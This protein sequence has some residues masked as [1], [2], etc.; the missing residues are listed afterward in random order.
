M[1]EETKP[2]RIR[3]HV[4][5]ILNTRQL[6]LNIGSSNHVQVGMQFDVVHARNHE[7]KDP[8]SGEFLG[9]LELPKKRV[10]IS[11]V[12]EKYS[13]AST[14]AREVNVGGRGVGWDFANIYAPPKWVTRYDTL[15]K[16]RSSFEEIDESESV[17]KVGDPVVEV[18]TSDAAES[19][20]FIGETASGEAHVS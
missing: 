15:K 3:G 17:V 13:I 1:S 10:K 6:A 20:E 16:S 4:A 12:A 18:V 7:L 5:A 9:K 8:I 19:L 2:H 11:E 14:L